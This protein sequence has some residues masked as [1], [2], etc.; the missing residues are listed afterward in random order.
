MLNKKWGV[1]KVAGSRP[2]QFFI[3]LALHRS[4]VRASDFLSEEGLRSDLANRG[5]KQAEIEALI[6]HAPSLTSARAQ[7]KQ[8]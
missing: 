6:Q 1:A 2:E 5:I 4:M 8:R 3:F 7:P